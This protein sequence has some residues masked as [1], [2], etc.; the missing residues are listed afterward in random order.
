MGSE[1]M[2]KRKFLWLIILVMC[3]GF[4]GISTVLY[5]NGN[6]KISE[7]IDDFDVYFSKAVLDGEDESGKLISDDNKTITF[8]TKDL[9][10]GG[11]TSVLAYEVTNA[12]RNYD[13]VVEISCTK[14]EYVTLNVSEE[15]FIV[16]ATNVKSGKV[17]VVLN[18]TALEPK[19]VKFTCNLNIKASERTELGNNEI[20]KYN[21]RAKY[22]SYE[23]NKTKLTCKTVQD[24]IN[25]IDNK[26]EV[27]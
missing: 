12:S 26:L 22:V 8:N 5:I 1:V 20:K 24:C 27:K 23:N 6:T 4:A 17:E 15:T 3:I 16:E 9:T 21:Y 11:D 10:L 2:K 13:A 19:E 7:N 14:P 18:K 25:E